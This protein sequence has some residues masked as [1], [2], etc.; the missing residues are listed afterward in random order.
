MKTTAMPDGTI[1]RVCEFIAADFTGFNIRIDEREYRLD[2]VDFPWFEYCTVGE[3]AD[4]HA[5]EWGVYWH[6]AE[7]DLSLESLERPKDFPCKFNVDRW[8]ELRRRKAAALMGRVRTPRKAAAS[9]RNGT[10]GGRPRKK[11][12]KKVHA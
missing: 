2:F 9:R 5:D 10:A 8:L 3:M 11:V 6:S 12:M 1:S 7:I 4:F